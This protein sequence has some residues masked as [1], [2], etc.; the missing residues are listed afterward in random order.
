[1]ILLLL[2]ASLDRFVAPM[3]S[4][5]MQSSDVINYLTLDLDQPVDAPSAD[6]DQVDVDGARRPSCPRLGVPANPTD[7]DAIDWFRTHALN[8]MRRQVETNR[9]NSAGSG[10]QGC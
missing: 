3:T 5:M 6:D 9:K 2:K 8:D 7:Y 1:M 10:C 4:T